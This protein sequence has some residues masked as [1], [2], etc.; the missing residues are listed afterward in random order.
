MGRRLRVNAG[1]YVYHA[2]NRANAR[3]R[4]FSTDG[5]Y[6][7][8]ERVLAQACERTQ[9]GLLSYC[10]MPNHWHLVLRPRKDGDLS[11]FMGWLTMTHTQRW[12]AHHQTVGMGHLYQGRFKSFL[13]Q[14]DSHFLML[15]RYVEANA[16]RA[17]LVDRAEQWRWC[18]LWRRSDRQEEGDAGIRLSKWPVDRPDNW[19]SIVNKMFPESELGRLQVSLKRDRP[20]G[21]PRWLARAVKR[22]GLESSIRPR[23]RPKKTTQTKKGS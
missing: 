20:Y 22:L 9:M 4:I 1:G 21:D 5:D 16:L 13:V 10:L 3:M 17:R 14:T 6:A 19:I 18:S 7:A 12:H 8:F 2:L 11:L 23:G 15:C